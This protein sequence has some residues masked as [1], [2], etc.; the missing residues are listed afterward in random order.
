MPPLIGLALEE[1]EPAGQ[2][3]CSDLCDEIYAGK[4]GPGATTDRAA[5]G[6]R[7]DL[8]E[9]FFSNEEYYSKLEEL[10][11]AH[12]RT[13]AEL[14]N[15]YRRKLQLKAMETLDPTLRASGRSDSSSS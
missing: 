2:R 1:P 12:L 10:K 3:R 11:K 9:I 5:A 6:E 15:M 13:M 7:L 8:S 14:E 4:G